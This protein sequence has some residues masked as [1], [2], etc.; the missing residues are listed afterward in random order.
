MR[1]SGDQEVV[2][3]EGSSKAMDSDTREMVTQKC[4]TIFRCSGSAITSAVVDKC[5]C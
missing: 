1:D 5:M 3:E 2:V 4:F